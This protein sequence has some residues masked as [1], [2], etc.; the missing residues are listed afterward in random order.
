MSYTVIFLSH[1]VTLL[2][3]NVA[4]LSH[5]VT[6]H[7]YWV[8]CVFLSGY[9]MLEIFGSFLVLSSN[10]LCFMMKARKGQNCLTELPSTEEK[11]NQKNHSTLQNKDTSPNSIT[12]YYP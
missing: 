12:N 1:N 6:L 10:L 8:C 4:L 7:V 3:H 5:N 9:N 2:S 11:E